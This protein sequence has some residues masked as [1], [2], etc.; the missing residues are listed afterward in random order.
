MNT[1]IT[2]RNLKNGL[3][4]FI[5]LLGFSARVEAISTEAELETLDGDV[6]FVQ[7]QFDH[8]S[9]DELTRESHRITHKTVLA[10]SDCLV[11]S[12]PIRSPIIEHQGAFDALMSE[13][14]SFAVAQGSCAL[15]GI[16]VRGGVDLG[17]WYR[18]RDSLISPAMVRA[19]NLEHRACVPM[20]AVT[21][22][23]WSYL[24]SHPDRHFYSST[25]DPFPRTLQRYRDLPNG[26]IHRFINYVRIC[27]E[28]V[29]GRLIGDE[30]TRYEAANPDERDRMRTEVWQRACRAWACDH[31]QSVT[32][33]HAASENVSVRAKYA[34]LAKYHNA[35]IR[36]FFGGEAKPLLV[37]LCNGK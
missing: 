23:L 17:M 18:R 20:I 28:S 35:E 30:R 24:A 2:R 34:W 3:T 19:Y 5:D 8:K 27:L 26:E 6:R 37:N 7:S 21:Q 15:R 10:F 4:A 16:F 22:E 1:R 9:P 25:I 33:A 13:L 31:A 32:H 36:R 29:E 14:T 12:V 11:I